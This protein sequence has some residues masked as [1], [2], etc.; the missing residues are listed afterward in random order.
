MSKYPAPNPP[1]LGPAKYYST[2]GNKPINRIVMHSTVGPTKGGSAR[3]VAN[4]FA[5]AVTR[6]SSAH[7]A[8]DAVEVVQVVF[9]GDTAYHAPPNAHS[10]GVEMCD[11]PHPTSGAR[12]EDKDHKALLNNAARLVAELCL[13]YDVPPW[14]V[15]P[16]RL[17]LGRRG[18]TTH[19]A[20]R[21]AWHQTDHW[22]PG[23]WPRRAFMREVRRQV[24]AIK[25][26]HG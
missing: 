1:Y 7:Y 17:R 9:D 6:P 12:W 16:V 26:A 13:A 10:I 8:V 4:Y 21:D 11:Y 25:K 2:G 23:A 22:D 24:K 19:A 3:G 5:H 15:G 14:F 18:V 20:V